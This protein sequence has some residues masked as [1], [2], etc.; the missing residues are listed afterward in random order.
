MGD[1]CMR[2]IRRPDFMKEAM[3]TKGHTIFLELLLAAA[4]FFV[5]SLVV[6]VLQFPFMMLYMFTNEEYLAM[7][8][9]ASIDMETIMRIATNLPMWLYAVSLI[10]EIGWIA[11]VLLYC[12]FI[13]KRSLRTLGF[14]K[15]KCILRY[16]AGAGLGFAGFVLVYGILLLTG[17][18]KLTASPENEMTLLYGILFF[19]GFMIQGMAEELFC[20]GYLLVSLSRRYTVTGSVVMSSLLFTALHGTNQGFSLL[21]SL[22][23]FLFGI[24][25]SLL[26]LRF[27]NI[28]LVAALHSIWNFVQGNIFGVSVSGSAVLPSV[29]GTSNTAGRDW[30]NGGSFGAEGGLAVTVILAAAIVVLLR[31]MRKQGYFEQIEPVPNMYSAQGNAWNPQNGKPPAGNPAPQRK[32]ENME[33]SPEETPWRYQQEREQAQNQVSGFDQSYFKDDK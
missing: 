25:L 7:L 24:L 16:L 27:E 20:R 26:F 14:S 15:K 12:R 2:D 6:S 21:A 22:N 13:E 1:L 19:I 23:L 3:N 29:F 31:L 32:Y 33:S 17:S 28:W 30:L 18:V 9:S 5:G 4:V 8:Q 10:A 11:V